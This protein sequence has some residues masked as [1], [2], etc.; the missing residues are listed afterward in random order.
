MWEMK[1]QKIA[2]EWM[3]A[4][5]VGW[6]RSLFD[7]FAAAIARDDFFGEET[8]ASVRCVELITTAYASARDA[9]ASS[10]PSRR[11]R[12][13]DRPRLLAGPR[14]GHARRRRRLRGSRL[15]RRGG[16]GV[17]HRAGRRARRCS[18]RRPWRWATGRCVRSARACIALGLSANAVSWASLALAALAG[19][20]LA[21]GA[22]RRRRRRQPRCRRRA[23]RSTA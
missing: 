19:V 12:A 8:E 3:D 7:Q 2:S 17:A 10:A 9:L 20:A 23:T 11:G 18:A 13:R 5:H 4:S 16:A 21:A 15:A 14:D 1:K 22:L 6:F